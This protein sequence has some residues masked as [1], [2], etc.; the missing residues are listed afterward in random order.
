MD[1]GF[2]TTSYIKCRVPFDFLHKLP[3]VVVVRGVDD[4]R[5]VEEE[6]V[7]RVEHIARHGLMVHRES[8]SFS[9]GR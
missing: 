9:L 7:F 1:N 2:N 4:E 3:G 6:G 5:L 8:Y